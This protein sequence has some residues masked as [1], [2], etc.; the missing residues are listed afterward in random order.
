MK[1]DK[2]KELPMELGKFNM[3]WRSDNGLFSFRISKNYKYNRKTYAQH[4]HDEVMRKCNLYSAKKENK[5]K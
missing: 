1:K 3:G 4:D 2:K 5:S